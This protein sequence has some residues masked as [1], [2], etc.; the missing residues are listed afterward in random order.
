MKIPVIFG[1][2]TNE[3]TVFTPKTTSS[4][5]Q[6][7]LFLLDQFPTY[8]TTELSTINSLYMS[9]P[10]AVTYPSAGSYWRVLSNAYGEIRYICPGIYISSAYHNHSE[11][12]SWNYHYAVLDEAAITSGYGTQHTIEINAIWG[13]GYVGGGSAPASYYS[14]GSN[15]DIVPLMQ[16][17][18]ASF[19]RAY[20]PN[21]Y[22]AEGAPE[23]APWDAGRQ[24]LFIRTNET[25]MQTTDEA[26]LDRCE[27]VQGMAVALEQ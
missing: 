4:V 25:H 8:T 2:D 18:W 22:R 1:D 26:Q 21:T 9:S 12:R 16:G 23:W 3:G 14:N 19:I 15:A 6:A 27:V 11:T 24:R 10:D 5:A 20:D 17:Y 13:P 7:D